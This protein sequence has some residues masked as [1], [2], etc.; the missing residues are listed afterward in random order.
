MKEITA[1]RS[2][3]GRLF[4]SEGECRRHELIINQAKDL[5]TIRKKL[6]DY[7]ADTFSDSNEVFEF[8]RFLDT[9]LSLL[10][11]TLDGFVGKGE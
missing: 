1:Y 4:D 10:G 3:D 5:E 8:L 9:T 6:N 2:M 7:A 11:H